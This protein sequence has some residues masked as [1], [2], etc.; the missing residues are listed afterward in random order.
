MSDAGDFCNP[1]V[2]NDSVSCYSHEA[3]IYVGDDEKSSCQLA[4]VGC[5]K[6]QIT[7]HGDRAA[8]RR[9]FHR[10]ARTKAPN[11]EGDQVTWT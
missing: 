2:K 10:G 5:Q 8:G 4:V 1:D 9:K 7:I 11:H 3:V 6:K